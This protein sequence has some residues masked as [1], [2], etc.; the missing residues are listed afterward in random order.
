MKKNYN[1]ILFSILFVFAS[2]CNKDLI[3]I[4]NTVIDK[5]MV[6]KTWH[7]DYSI[8]GTNTQSFV[9][10]TSYSITYFKDGT[11]KDSD[12]LTGVYKISEKN[13]IYQIQVVATSLNGNALNYT[14]TIES[15][16]ESHMVQSFTLAGQESKTSLY[17]TS[18]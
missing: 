11:T 18:K 5:M 9:G 12:G 7:L 17:F 6:N 4:T 14:H 1:I 3:K 13:G 8:I 2:A 15:V 10:Q 16:G